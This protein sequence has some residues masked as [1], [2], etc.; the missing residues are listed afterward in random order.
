MNAI[1]KLKM[2]IILE[3]FLLFTLLSPDKIAGCS[4]EMKFL[5][6]LPAGKHTKNI[7][8]NALSDML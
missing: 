7:R 8:K 3:V 1:I 5:N 2:P 4:L 6:A